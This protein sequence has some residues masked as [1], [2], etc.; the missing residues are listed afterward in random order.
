MPS[1]N[2]READLIANIEVGGQTLKTRK[3]EIL[4]ESR[5]LGPTTE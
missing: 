5:T 4:C 3:K 1:P 2:C